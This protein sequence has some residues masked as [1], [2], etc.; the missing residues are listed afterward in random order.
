LPELPKSF[1]RPAIESVLAQGRRLRFTSFTSW[2]LALLVGVAALLVVGA[3]TLFFGAR[4]ASEAKYV[5]EPVARGDLTAI[6]TATG[7]VQPTNQAEISSELSG[8]V[9]QVLVDFNSKVKIGTVLAELDTDKLKATVASSRAKLASAKAKVGNAK[10]TEIETKL[11][12]ERKLALVANKIS[13]EQDVDTAKAAADRAVASVASAEADVGVAEAELQLDETDLAKCQILSP[14]D[15]VVLNRNV[16]PG[17]TVA[18]SLQAPILFTI[19]EDLT[20]MEVQ[21]D[22]DEADVG[23][24]KEGQVATFSVDAF[25]DRKFQAEIRELRFG[26]EVVQGVVTYKAV[27][28]TDNSE[29]LLRPGMTAT[30]EITVRQVKDAL[31]VPN[32]ALRFSPPA[33]DVQ[34]ISLLQRLLPGRTQF[35]PASKKEASNSERRVWLLQNGE[36]VAVPVIVGLTDGRR[37]EILQS[38]LKEGQAIIVDSAVVK[39]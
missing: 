9:R 4:S 5:T 8:T 14:I 13:S 38:E 7:T 22:V 27:L 15:G 3:Y 1:E 34:R 18:S 30:A 12:Y 25:P 10:A 35:R 26:S 36:P 37:T 28:T 32:A 21:V 16:D 20:K 6:V 29:L 17:Q 11:V 33:K 39:R 23:S 2:Q 24:V 31:T 19:A